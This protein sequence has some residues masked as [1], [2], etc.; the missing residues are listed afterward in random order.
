MSDA[1]AFDDLIGR[2]HRVLNGLLDHRTGQ[3]TT[4]SSK[5]A[6]L[7]AFSVFFTQSPSFPAH[8]RTMKQNKGHS[9][10]ESLFRIKKV[11]CDNQIRNLLDPIAPRYLFPMFEQ[12]FSDLEA[13]E[14][15]DAFSFSQR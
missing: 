15:L 10:A 3:N 9:N 4:Y 13:T 2:F 12:V 5:D 8:Q 1:L 6:A 7:S 14:E 11:P